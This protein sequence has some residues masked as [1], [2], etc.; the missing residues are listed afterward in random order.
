[1]MS[2]RAHGRG[3]ALLS[4]VVLVVLFVAP[5]QLGAASSATSVDRLS[6]SH[7]VNSSPCTE[8]VRNHSFE[9]TGDWQLVSSPR[10]ASYTVDAAHSGARSMRT[11]VVPPTVDGYSHSPF[12]QRIS[13][14][15]GAPNPSLSFWYKA[16]SEDLTRANWQAFDWSGYDPAAIIAGQEVDQRCCGGGDWQEMLLLDA[17][18]RLLPGGVVLRQVRNDGTWVQRTFDLSPFRGQTV[19]LYYNTI[20]DGNGRRTWMYVD[21]VSV[22]LCGQQARIDPPYMQVNVG[23]VFSVNVRVENVR[24]LYGIDT[25]LRFNPAILEVVDANAGA[26]GIQVKPGDWLPPSTHIVTNQADNGV[27]TIYFAAS[28][29]APQP[30][31]YGSGN[32]VS[33]SFRAKAAGSSAVAFDALQLVDS[34]ATPIPVSPSNGSVTV[35]GTHGTLRGQVLLE[36][37]NNHGGTRVQLDG[38]ATIISGTDGRYSFHTSGGGHAL[39]FTRQS[40][41]RR[42]LQANVQPGGTTTLPTFA[43]LSGD[44]N[45]DASINILDLTAVAAQFGSINPSPPAVDINADGRVDIIDIVLVAKNF[46]ATA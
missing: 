28:L 16:H 12:Y 3:T 22:N 5:A 33:I 8:L 17:N 30:G 20:N 31:L 23:Q 45:Q 1:M 43:L 32:L 10:M 26:P 34:N 37:R 15:A 18:Y 40:Y 4:L 24:D 9:W 36:G 7:A 6:P 35:T 46:G 41:L 21:D 14:P 42:T 27:G 13:I 29:V 11:G 19:V 25:R 44:V 2:R 38:G 39:L